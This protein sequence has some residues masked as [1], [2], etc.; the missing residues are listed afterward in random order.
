MYLKNLLLLISLSIITSNLKAQLFTLKDVASGFNKP[1][2]ISNSGIPN[3]KRLFITEKD[4]K[5]KIIDETG[6]V[7]PTPF[8]DID[9]KVNSVSNERGLLG[10]CFH[11]K[12]ATNG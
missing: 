6:S 11:P 4:G 2:D 5:I 9:N 10:L 1:V 7:L 8:I 3:D 12:Y